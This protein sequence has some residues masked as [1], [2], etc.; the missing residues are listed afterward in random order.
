MVTARYKGVQVVSETCG[1]RNIVKGEPSADNLIQLI[2]QDGPFW[3]AF[4]ELA[5]SMPGLAAAADLE[6]LRNEWEW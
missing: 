2:R 3:E 4:H 6:E 1:S 5:G